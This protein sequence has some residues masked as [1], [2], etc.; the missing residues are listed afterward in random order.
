MEQVKKVE[1]RSKPEQHVNVGQAEIRI[2]QHDPFA[3]KGKATRKVDGQ[4]GFTHTT[5]TGG[6]GDDKRQGVHIFSS[7]WGT[8]LRRSG[9]GR[10]AD[11]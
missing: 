5:L 9:K 2:K 4:V 3:R 11:V 6:D 8:R 1:R 10:E 7:K